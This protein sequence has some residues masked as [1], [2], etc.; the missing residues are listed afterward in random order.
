M[1][2]PT[3]PASGAAIRW[4]LNFKARYIAKQPVERKHKKIFIYLI[5]H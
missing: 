4:W 1:E 3:V 2:L 5:F